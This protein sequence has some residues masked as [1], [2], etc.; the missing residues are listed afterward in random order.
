LLNL[1]KLWWLSSRQ[2]F[3]ILVRLLSSSSLI[4]LHQWN[5]I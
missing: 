4:F 3:F 2:I 5:N 1:H